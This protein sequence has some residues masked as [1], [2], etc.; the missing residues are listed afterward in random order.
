[1]P[2]VI[3]NPEELVSNWCIS[4]SGTPD[5]LFVRTLRGKRL[6]YPMIAEIIK[7][8]TAICSICWDNWKGDCKCLTNGTSPKE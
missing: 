6:T 4:K 1:M 5:N 8:E 2:G 3:H 7:A